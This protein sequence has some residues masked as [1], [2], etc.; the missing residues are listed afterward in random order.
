MPTRKTFVLTGATSG[1]GLEIARAL[2]ADPAARLIVG[3]RSPGTASALRALAGPER[4]T[5]ARL[6]T[7]DL[8]AVAAFA[9]EVRGAL[10]GEP[11][12]GL[13]LNAGVQLTG[14]L[15][16]VEPGLERTFATNH[17]GHFA[18]NHALLD[19]LAPGAPV[20]ST[21][22]GT[23]DPADR[24]ARIFGFRG[25]IFPSADRV[26]RGD[27]DPAASDKQ[28]GMDRYATSKLCQILFTMEMARR[29]PEERARFVAFDPGLTPGTGLARQRSGLER[30][31]WANVLPL[32]RFAMPGMST[33]ARSG[34]AF[35]AI[36]RGDVFPVGSGLHVDFTLVETA[37]STD[38]MRRDLA[39]E[40]Y[41]TSLRLT[42]LEG[43]AAA[44]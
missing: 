22:S 38:A 3:A 42:G 7:A 37:P 8:G 31:G 13:G 10:G 6:D 4:L 16:L 41:E 27:L 33:P 12:A 17:L 9:A 15:D 5:I 43:S 11:I 26:A 39:A 25:G 23:H 36:L 1:I 30:W 35:A 18:L 21:A 19:M 32:L 2:L 20:I 44:A 29:V 34:Q 14:A 28:L 24:G 40:L